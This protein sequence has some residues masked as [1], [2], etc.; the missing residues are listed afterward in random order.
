[1]YLDPDTIHRKVHLVTIWQLTDFK[2]MQGNAGMGPL[3]LDPTDFY[4]RR[5]TNN[6]IVLKSASDCW[7]T[8]SSYDIWVPTDGM[9]DT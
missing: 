4:R 2:W 3:D 1:V 5:P 8:W 6:S 7:R 9:L